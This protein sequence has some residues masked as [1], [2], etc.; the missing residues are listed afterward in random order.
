MMPLMLVYLDFINKL[1]I[2][3]SVVDL[4]ARNFEYRYLRLYTNER[5]TV[6][7]ML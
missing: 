5:N 7:I 3:V 6:V 2:G 1:Y 4:I